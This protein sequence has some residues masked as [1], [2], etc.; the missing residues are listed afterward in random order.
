[1]P[2]ESSS[3]ETPSVE[4]TPPE[5]PLE[6]LEGC[7]QAPEGSSDTA[8]EDELPP[9]EVPPPPPAVVRPFSFDLPKNLRILF[10]LPPQSRGNTS[11]IN[12]VFL[13]SD[14]FGSFDKYG[15][16]KWE[17]GMHLFEGRLLT[18]E[19]FLSPRV[20]K[21]QLDDTLVV[22]PVVHLCVLP[23]GATPEKAPIQVFE[24][25]SKDEAAALIRTLDDHR[26]QC[27]ELQMKVDELTA[28]NSTLNEAIRKIEQREMQQQPE[29]QPEEQPQQP[30]KK[31]PGRKPQA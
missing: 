12:G 15:V 22:R 31:K 27:R 17:R 28:E 18:L 29:E 13:Y 21:Y 25:I 26:A 24:G 1:M 19:E 6:N 11:R 16:H 23:D 7:P 5:T 3:S 2:D 8:P 9:E 30:A 10:H 4:P 14:K 20:Q